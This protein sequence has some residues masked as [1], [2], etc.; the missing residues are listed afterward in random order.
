L[1]ALRTGA[2]ADRDRPIVF[3]GGRNLAVQLPYGGAVKR[4]NAIEE[5]LSELDYATA[6]GFLIN[7]LKREELIAA[8]SIIL[9][10]LSSTG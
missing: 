2:P 10:E 7:G 1:G 6:R 8:N 5:K 4:L 3:R 9:N